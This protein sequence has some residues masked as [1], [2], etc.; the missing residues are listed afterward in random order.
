M[1][2]EG[3]VRTEEDCKREL[4]ET[5]DDLERAGLVVVREADIGGFVEVTAVEF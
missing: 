4:S 5:L 2:A 3:R 1:F